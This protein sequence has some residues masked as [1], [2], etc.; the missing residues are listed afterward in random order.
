MSFAV[1]G[2]PGNLDLLKKNFLPNLIG[3]REIQLNLTIK[4]SFF[5][6]F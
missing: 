1:T 2:P 4:L 6:R 5:G 3:S